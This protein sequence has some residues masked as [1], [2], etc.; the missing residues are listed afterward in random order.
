[1]T[2]EP[3]YKCSAHVV[4]AAICAFS[5]VPRA[6]AAVNLGSSSWVWQNPLPQGNQLQGV[7]CS[8]AGGSLN[9]NC[10]GALFWG[11][12]LERV[13]DP[14]AN[15]RSALIPNIRLAGTGNAGGI[16]IH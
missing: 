11:Q 2:K 6:S 16:V 1:M 9:L 12:Q 14:A 10:L 15:T 4:V 7:A 13:P 3:I 8:L 5:A